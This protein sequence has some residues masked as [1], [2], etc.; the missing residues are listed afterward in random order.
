MIDITGM[1]VMS[2]MELNDL[3]AQIDYLIRTTERLKT[4]NM[5]LRHKLNGSIRE[6]TQL[7]ERNQNASRQI[8]R[9][10]SQL[11]ENYHE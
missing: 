4:E 8:K 9:I 5:S 3:E 2:T 10:I 11:K 6:R 1:I 7:L